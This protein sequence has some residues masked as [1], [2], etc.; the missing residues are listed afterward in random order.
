MVTTNE[1]LRSGPGVQL[2][3]G[4][5][6]GAPPRILFFHLDNLRCVTFPF[7]ALRLIALSART[8]GIDSYNTWPKGIQPSRHLLIT[9]DYMTM[10]LKHGQANLTGAIIAL[11]SALGVRELYTT[12]SDGESSP[13]ELP[14]LI[15]LL[16]PTTHGLPSA[17]FEHVARGL[18]KNALAVNKVW[19][20]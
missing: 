7:P 5:D 4:H 2:A 6:Y 11:L 16:H 1:I 20:I 10:S 13:L 8:G 15:D 12:S 14:L 17:K 18:G 3:F 9:G 19:F